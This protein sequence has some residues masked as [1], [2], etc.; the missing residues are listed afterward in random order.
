LNRDTLLVS[1]AGGEFAL[2]L[3]RWHGY[4]A[5]VF[6]PAESSRSRGLRHRRMHGDES[7]DR[8]VERSPSSAA[9]GFQTHH[10][11]ASAAWRERLPHEQRADK[12]AC[13]RERSEPHFRVVSLPVL[14]RDLAWQ[15]GALFESASRRGSRLP[16]RPQLPV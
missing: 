16:S 10:E 4:A 6:K 11:L 8:I 15:P 3:E 13:R 2:G 5:G 9:A 12:R 7:P 1:R 14:F